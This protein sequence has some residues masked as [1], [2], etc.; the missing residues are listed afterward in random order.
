LV[1]ALTLFWSFFDLGDV[2]DALVTTRILGLFL[3]QVFAVMLLRR[4]PNAH[5]PFQMWLY[6]LPCAIAVAGWGYMYVT[7]RLPFIVFSL[8]VLTLGMLAFL[9]WARWTGSWPFGIR[10]VTVEV[11]SLPAGDDER[12]SQLK[13]M[14]NRRGGAFRS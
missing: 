7:S 13:E 1:A 14:A 12:R 6:P 3:A 10:S 11:P 2:I 9:L 8:A 4:Q 5:L